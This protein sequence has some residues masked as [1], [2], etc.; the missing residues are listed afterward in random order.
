M[1][2]KQRALK[3]LEEHE[4]VKGEDTVIADLWRKSSLDV[5]YEPFRQAYHSYEPPV[6]H[7]NEDIA[8]I[9]TVCRRENISSGELGEAEVTIAAW[10]VG[11]ESMAEEYGSEECVRNLRQGGFVEDGGLVVSEEFTQVDMA[12][13]LDG[14]E[15]FIKR[16]TNDE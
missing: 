8:E 5:S 13:L 3:W 6:H 14:A 9:L 4:P 12:L 15:G 16:E 1:T 10:M 7:E 2:Q 11:G